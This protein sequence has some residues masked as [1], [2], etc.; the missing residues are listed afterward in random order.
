[1]GVDNTSK[2]RAARETR[3]A[4]RNGA[5]SDDSHH[6]DTA[7]IPSTATVKDS[8]LRV[9]RASNSKRRKD[10]HDSHRENSHRQAANRDTSRANQVS[11]ALETTRVPRK[12]KQSKKATYQ[13]ASHQQAPHRHSPWENKLA[14]S[15]EPRRVYQAR[16]NTFAKRGVGSY[17][18]S[19]VTVTGSECIVHND[20]LIIEDSFDTSEW[21]ESPRNTNRFQRD[22]EC[23]DRQRGNT[24]KMRPIE[25]MISAQLAHDS[26]EDFREQA[27]RA[28]E[29][30][31]LAGVTEAEIVKEEPDAKRRRRN[32]VML[33]VVLLLIVLGAVGTVVGIRSSRHADLVGSTFAPTAS[34]TGS[35]GVDASLSRDVCKLAL[36]LQF[37]SNSVRASTMKASFQDNIPVCAPLTANG[38]GVSLM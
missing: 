2:R 14:V 4:V 22:D 25:T 33:G 18:M 30:K 35:P 37:V 1:M 24:E 6:I 13:V 20:G 9:P 32:R 27:R 28:A 21:Q 36:E 7:A 29:A 16:D 17:D 38:K 12:S 3:I 23:V 15:S 34:P 11:S 10:T 31:I 19:P 26:E 8:S 5:K